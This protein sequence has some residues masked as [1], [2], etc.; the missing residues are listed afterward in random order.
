MPPFDRKATIVAQFAEASAHSALSEDGLAELARVD[1]VLPAG[2]WEVWTS[3][4]FRRITGSDGKD[5]G[6]LSGIVQRSDGHADLSMPEEQLQA[7]VALRNALPSMLAALRTQQTDPDAAWAE[8]EKLNAS[9]LAQQTTNR[10]LWQ[11]IKDACDLLAERTHGSPTRS[12]GHNARLFLEDA[13]RPENQSPSILAAIR[14]R[15]DGE[16]R[17]APP[18]PAEPTDAM[19]SAMMVAAQLESVDKPFLWSNAV[20]AAYAAMLTA[21]PAPRPQPVP[22]G[23][24]SVVA[25]F[26]DM[27]RLYG[28]CM[29]NGR[30]IAENDLRALLSAY[31]GTG[32]AS[33]NVQAVN[34]VMAGRHAD[35]GRLMEVTG[36]HNDGL[37]PPVVL[38]ERCLERIE[39]S[40]GRPEGMPGVEEIGGDERRCLERLSRLDYGMAL[41]ARTLA[42][43]TGLSEPVARGVARLL[44]ARGFVQVLNGLFTDDGEVAG[45][46]YALS[47]EGRKL[48]SRLTK[49]G[50]PNE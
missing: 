37:S 12:P 13:I 15:Q 40:S 26:A 7:L 25:E 22:E 33:T 1:A 3:C 6:V 5:G 38:F 42:A 8:V 43:D 18:L 16:T 48:L 47:D 45:S 24:R 36:V 21:L 4:S 9:W 31:P 19:V 17:S 32:E 50:G 46:G 44:I 11:A 20:R 35:L 29:F 27:L 14:A 2:P 39:A 10:T 34:D 23:V 28:P 41:Y 30:T 49:T